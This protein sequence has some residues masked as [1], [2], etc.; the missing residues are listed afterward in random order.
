MC[1][2]THKNDPKGVTKRERKRGEERE[3][4]RARECDEHKKDSTFE[5]HDFLHGKFASK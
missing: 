1:T 2:Q 4:A 5:T 3:G